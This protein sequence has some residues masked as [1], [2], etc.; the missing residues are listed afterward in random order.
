[1]DLMVRTGVTVNH[2]SQHTGS[3]VSVLVVDDD[4]DLRYLIRQW[5]SR[6]D[7][8]Q[9]VGEADNGA[10]AIEAARRL[11]PDLVVMDV[12]IPR[13]DGG[14]ATRIIGSLSP[15]TR[16]LAH[17]ALVDQRYV[18][19][20]IGAGVHGYL[21]KSGS[22]EQFLE[23]L[24]VVAD[25]RTYLSPSAGHEVFEH[26]RSSVRRHQLIEHA[27]APQALSIAMQPIVEIATGGTVGYE[28]LA[29]FPHDP[30]GPV[31]AAAIA[32][33][34]DLEVELAAAHA[35]LETVRG[36]GGDIGFV[37]VNASPKTV[38][39]A[40]FR[41]VLSIAD[42][43]KTVIELTENAAVH[44]YAQLRSAI[45]PLRAQGFRIAIDDVG[46]GFSCLTHVHQ[47]EPDLIKVDRYLVQAIDSD[48]VRQIM[49]SSLAA[50]A[51]TSG[52]RLVAEGVE[53]QAELSTVRDLGVE[54]A[55][56]YL[57]GA[58]EAVTSGSTGVT[59]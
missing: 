30:P 43:D 14:E 19:E 38:M 10:E 46:G 1:M 26:V 32:E 2:Q 5:L 15:R 36:L 17:T 4:E 33:G 44:D 20:M 35:A 23:A 9:I 25:G 39:T 48:P 58:P 50:I 59:G 49:V 22:G 37:C 52:A 24:E 18:L 57:F 55:Q 6:S 8:F 12:R 3:S 7:R 31:F 53:T 34:R 16:V 40:A 11:K 47:L 54:L 56:G 51:A 42:A 29:R 21:V 41:D 28:A 45:D 27:M 13:S